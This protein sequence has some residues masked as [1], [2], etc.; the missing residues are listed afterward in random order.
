[1]SAAC[2]ISRIPVLESLSS[3]SVASVLNCRVAVGSNISDGPFPVEP[4][5]S[6]F[7]MES[8][9]VYIGAEISW[10]RGVV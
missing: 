10:S 3:V 5:G 1:M 9:S 4:S 7:H 8:V 6:F 2:D